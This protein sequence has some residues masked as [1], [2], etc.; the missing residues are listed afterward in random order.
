MAAT[1]LR[2]LASFYDGGKN[3]AVSARLFTDIIEAIACLQLIVYE[4]LQ[5]A[6]QEERQFRAFSKWLRHQI[7]LA[8]AEPGSTGT[9][10]MAEREAAN[11]DF[12][13][14]LAYIEGPLVNSRL[15]S[16][17]PDLEEADHTADQLT[18]ISPA[19]VVDHIKAMR[20]AQNVTEK[21]NFVGWMKQL[22]RRIAT[23][24]DGMKVW[25]RSMWSDPIGVAIEK[26]SV[27]DA[28]DAKMT[29]QVSSL[30]LL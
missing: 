3:F 17:V 7:D 1:T 24:L 30:E 27:S 20:E 14:N 6:G 5:I 29:C 18:D 25:Q 15:Q 10:E 28:T 22:S 26:G 21:L 13:R 12:L 2:G 19:A 16:I 8:A 9:Q 23:A 11:M 4:V